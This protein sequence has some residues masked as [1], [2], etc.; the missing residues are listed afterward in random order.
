MNEVMGNF[1]EKYMKKNPY[2]GYD[3]RMYKGA[4]MEDMAI[5]NNVG[6]AAPTAATET[7]A[8]VTAGSDAIGAFSETNIQVAGVDESEI[9]KTNGKNVYYYNQKE[10]RVY[11][12][13]V[14]PAK[15]MKILRS[16]VIPQNWS[17][18]ELYIQ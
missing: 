13:Q 17:S 7:S 6:S 3:G 8:P 4:I 18:P 15:D 10:N 1:I 5:S 12:A 16:I 9:V 2:G 14:T 11:I